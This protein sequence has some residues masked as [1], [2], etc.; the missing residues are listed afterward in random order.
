MKTFQGHTEASG[1]KLWRQLLAEQLAEMGGIKFSETLKLRMIK[2]LVEESSPESIYF[3]S[4][5]RVAIN[6]IDIEEATKKNM[7]I[8]MGRIGNFQER[9]SKWRVLGIDDVQ[10]VNIVV[11]SSTSGSSYIKLPECL[12]ISKTDLI[13]LQNEHEKCFM[14]CH[15][16]HINPQ[17]NDSQNIRKNDRGKAKT[18]NYKDIEFPVKIKDIGKIEKQNNINISLFGKQEKWTYTGSRLGIPRE[19]T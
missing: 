18:F 3:N 15:V 11:Y 1:N 10:F 4:F 14:W 5:A 9:G 2:G 17:E 6:D 19:T 8:I 13:N 16:R 12:N 7:E